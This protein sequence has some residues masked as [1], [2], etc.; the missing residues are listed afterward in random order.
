MNCSLPGSAVCGVFLA[1]ILEWVAIFFYRDCMY[2]PILL[3]QSSVDG[4]LDCF[5]TLAFVDNAAMN[6][7][8]K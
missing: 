2:I 5:H 7:I 8:Y 3:I 1:R 6:M 4:Y